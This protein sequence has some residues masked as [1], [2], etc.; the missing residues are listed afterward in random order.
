MVTGLLLGVAVIAAVV[1][2]GL[3]RLHRARL[4]QAARTR[5]GASAENAIF[6]RSY[7]EMDERLGQRWCSCG[8]Y[9]E[10]TGEGTRDIGGRRFRV[11]RLACQECERVEEVFFDTTDLLH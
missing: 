6:I 7:T 1:A 2:V 11:A 8:G 10:R 4:R 9:L 3:R 5:P